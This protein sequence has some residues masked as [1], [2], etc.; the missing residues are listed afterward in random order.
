MRHDTLNDPKYE[1]ARV[2]RHQLSDE[3]DEDEPPTSE[4]DEDDQAPQPI[5]KPLPRRVDNSTLK[6][7]QPSSE[8]QLSKDDENSTLRMVRTDDRE[9]GKAVTHQIVSNA[10]LWF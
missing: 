3:E 7:S 8:P 10:I 1:G 4:E 2:S 9:K 5:P 6:Q